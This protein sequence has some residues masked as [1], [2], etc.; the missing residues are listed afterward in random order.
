MFEGRRVVVIRPDRPHSG[1]S[2]GDIAARCPYLVGMA[3][4]AVPVAE[5]SVSRRNSLRTENQ[6]VRIDEKA[7]NGPPSSRR[8]GT[9]QDTPDRVETEVK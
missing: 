7:A 8:G 4:G 5:R 9:S 2:G 1:F 3:R 6:D